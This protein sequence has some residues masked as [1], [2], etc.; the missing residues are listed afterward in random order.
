MPLWGLGTGRSLRR[1]RRDAA[2]YRRAL[3]PWQQ[4]A[5]A[6][7][8]H[9]TVAHTF[10]GADAGDEPSVPLQ[11]APGER[12]FSVLERA[13][14]EVGQGQF[15]S[16]VGPSGSGK[17]SLLRAVIGLQPPLGGSIELTSVSFGPPLMKESRA[18]GA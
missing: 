1:Y 11:L 14:L 9:L 2:A 10:A 6:L 15:V 16:L 18:P 3:E 5:D 12:A 17:S 7:R 13:S 8:A 4:E